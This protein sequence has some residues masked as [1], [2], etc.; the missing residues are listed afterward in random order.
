[1]LEGNLLIRKGVGTTK[2]LYYAVLLEF[3]GEQ[4]LSQGE[5][6]GLLREMES[7]G[8]VGVPSFESRSW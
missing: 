7:S 5:V 3:Q 6:L 1:L 8:S 2:E 4:T